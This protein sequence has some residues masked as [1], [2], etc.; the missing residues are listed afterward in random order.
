MTLAGDGNLP[1]PLFDATRGVCTNVPQ[2]V[3]Y[4]V[5]TVD[6]GVIAEVRVDV[7]IANVSLV[8]TGALVAQQAFSVTFRSLS[9]AVRPP[10]TLTRC[11]LCRVEI[12]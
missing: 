5:L 2:R 11:A 10:A 8:A 4:S 6:G 12:H 3:A 7:V 9:S 1:E